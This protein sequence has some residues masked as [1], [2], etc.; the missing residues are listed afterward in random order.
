MRYR[1]TLSL[2]LLCATIVSLC[3]CTQTT[4]A[5]GKSETNSTTATVADQ[6]AQAY[7]E[8]TLNLTTTQNSHGL[9]Q[10]MPMHG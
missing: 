5:S 7:I 3:S 10:Q 6:E 8:E 1:K 2:L 9:T 4:E